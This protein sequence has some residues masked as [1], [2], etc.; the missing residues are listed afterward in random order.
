MA[1]L[2]KVVEKSQKTF[3]TEQEYIDYICNKYGSKHAMNLIKHGLSKYQ[4]DNQVTN[5]TVE[6]I[7]WRRYLHCLLL[8]TI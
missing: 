8:N 6:E 1:K 2:Y 7:L 5:L 4:K 3:N